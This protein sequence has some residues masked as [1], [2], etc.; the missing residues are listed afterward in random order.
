MPDM[1]ETG[2][3]ESAPDL[4]ALLERAQT[5]QARL[6]EAREELERSEIEGQS[7]GGVVKVRATA[8]GE[9]LSVSID[10][11]AVDPADT[12]MLEDLVLAALRDATTR[13]RELS[14]EALSAVDFGGAAGLFG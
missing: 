13:I 9:Y 7:G 2:A 10:P 14:E 1:S 3:E 12:E 11:K 8:A 6:A 4:A 5:M